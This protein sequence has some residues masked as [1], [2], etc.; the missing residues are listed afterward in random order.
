[1]QTATTQRAVRARTKAAAPFSATAAKL[2]QQ[3]QAEA[4]EQLLAELSAKDAVTVL[5]G[6]DAD[7]KTVRYFGGTIVLADAK[8]NEIRLSRRYQIPAIWLDQPHMEG[9]F[10]PAHWTATKTFV[11]ATGQEWRSFIDCLV[12]DD[13]GN[14]VQVAE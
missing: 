2:I 9:V 3:V 6:L 13:F 4:R 14:L 10:H 1:M 7:T 8:R 11:D 12:C 5:H